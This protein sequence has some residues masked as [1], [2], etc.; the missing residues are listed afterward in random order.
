M[1]PRERFGKIVQTV[2]TVC[3]GSKGRTKRAELDVS[4][5]ERCAALLSPVPAA[6]NKLFKQ[7]KRGKL[8]DRD[9]GAP[10]AAGF[11]ATFAAATP[12]P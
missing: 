2:Q 5:G 12:S 11:S 10:Y 3:A 8:W 1:S 6:F 4:I 9:A 7:N